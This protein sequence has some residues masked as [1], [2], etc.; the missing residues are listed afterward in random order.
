MDFSKFSDDNFDMKDWIN[1]ALRVQ[2][3][4]KVTVDAHTSNLVMKLQLFIQEVS[5]SLEETSQ[6]ALNNMPRVLREVETIRSETSLLKNQMMMVKDDIKK[7]EENTAQSMKKLV[8]IDRVKGRMQNACNALEEADNWSTLSSDVNKLFEAGEMD[9]VAEKLVGMQKSLQVLKDVPDYTERHR[10]LETL[11]VKL[12]ASLSPK[13]VQTF[14]QH[15]L[16]NARYYVKIFS[17]LNRLS[18]LQTYYSNCHK[19][20]LSRTWSEIREDPNTQITTWL[21]TYY[22]HLLALWH[23]EVSWCGQVFP[24]P[25]QA[26]CTLIAQTL[27]SLHPSIQ[28]CMQDSLHNSENSLHLLIELKIITKRFV[29]GLENAVQGYQ[30]PSSKATQDIAMIELIDIVKNPFLPH[31]LQY[32]NL[33]Q[34]SLMAVIDAIPKDT[35]DIPETVTTMANSI[36]DIFRSAEDALESCIKF[37]SGYGAAGL[38]D[39]LQIFFSAYLGHLDVM[40]KDMRRTCHLEHD[41]PIEDDDSANQWTNFQYGFKIIEM[42]GTLLLKMNAFC[43]SMCTQLIN[44]FNSIIVE[45]KNDTNENYLKSSRPIDWDKLRELHEKVSTY[46]V[47]TILPTIQDNVSKLNEFAHKFAF[48]VIFIH[49]KRQ[50]NAIPKFEIWCQSLQEGLDGALPTFSLSPLG[51]ITQVGDSLL[52]LPQ[53][54]EPFFVQDNE[55]LVA[56]LKAG[57][58]PYQEGK[59]ETGAQYDHHWLE[60]FAQGVISVY[61]ENILKIQVISVHSTRQLLADI[62]YFCNILAALEIPSSLELNNI[63]ELLEV[64]TKDF[65]Q[66]VEDIDAPSSIFKSIMKM[67][68]IQK[69][70]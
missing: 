19:S 55:Y 3:D 11:K 23:R 32:S 67:R 51:Y 57:K 50:L 13:I 1:N 14:N 4:T 66:K 54:L 43:I 69:T 52:M 25:V 48:D 46:G 5:K 44:I 62:E 17:E 60:S 37:T 42:C 27:N 2:K 59:D 16:E 41:L 22:D 12:E 8:E 36:S 53:Q 40:L 7:V 6:V 24:E 15:D 21:P 64:D 10:F 61:T 49:L 30:V 56:A 28:D 33:Q 65:G 45:P 68:N 39:A 47:D 58:I 34:I 31:L 38:V 70:N 20:S 18:Q 29:Q 35:S 9:L 63:K 26:L